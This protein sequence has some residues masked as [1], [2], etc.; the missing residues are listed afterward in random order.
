MRVFVR[1]DRVTAISQYQWQTK[2]KLSKLTD[3]QLKSEAQK[4]IQF[5]ETKQK[6]LGK[7]LKSHNY[8][9][10]LLLPVEDRDQIRIID[11][12]PFGYR[13]STT[14]VLFHWIRDFKKL[15]GEEDTETTYIRILDP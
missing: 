5:V 3:Q 11:L 15:Y 9:M 12:N 8:V 1:N 7:F 2:G 13:Q 6:N 10:D 4:I 14:S